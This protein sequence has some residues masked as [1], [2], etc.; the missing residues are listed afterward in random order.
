MYCTVLKCT[1][2]RAR[3]EKSGRLG[4]EQVHRNGTAKSS[5]THSNRQFKSSGLQKQNNSQQ[6]NQI[7]R[8]ET[9]VSQR[10]RTPRTI[11]VLLGTRIR[12]RRR[13]HYQASSSN[14]SWSKE[15]KPIFGITYFPSYFV[16][17][18]KLSIPARVCCYRWNHFH[19]ELREN[20]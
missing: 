8:Y 4:L 13:L 12:K 15:I 6:S 3:V 18:G 7:I 10:Q 17:L 20:Q 16:N 5:N 11:Q 19:V 9:V 1:E 14:L 2:M